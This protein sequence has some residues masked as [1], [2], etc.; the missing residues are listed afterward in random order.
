MASFVTMRDDDE[1]AARTT[2]SYLTLPGLFFPD[3]LSCADVQESLYDESGFRFKT[4]SFQVIDPASLQITDE[5]K[6]RFRK[7]MRTLDLKPFMRNCQLR[8]AEKLHELGLPSESKVRNV[9]QLL[10]WK[11]Y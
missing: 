4:T 2:L 7:A 6:K 5:Q 9:H 8:S 1:G 10:M 3:S 11:I